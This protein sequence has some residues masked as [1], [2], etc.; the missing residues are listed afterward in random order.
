MEASKQ[1]IADLFNTVA[2]TYDTV[3]PFFAT[4]AAHLV[5]AAGLK[6]GERVLDLACGRGACLKEAVSAV[7]ERGYVLGLDISEQMVDITA[8]EL[9][10]SGIENAE[11]RG[12]DAEQ[13]DLAS[14]SFDAILCGFGVFFFPNPHAA[15]MECLR[16]LRPGGRLAVSIFAGGRGGYPW[17]YDIAR[18]LGKERQVSSSPLRTEEGLRTALD[19][20]GFKRTRTED[21]QARFIV[22]NVDALI[23]WNR[24]VA[25]RR[26]LDSLSETELSRYRRLAAEHLKSH[27][28][29]GG[30]ELIQSAHLTVAYRDLDI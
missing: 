9:C 22:E 24:S 28:V 14:A 3:I 13:L 18:E 30:F 23:A 7:G 29:P 27:A 20:A 19:R 6:Q 1:H 5:K 21:C 26:L 10:A 4:F 8:N 25:Q 15:L 2:V 16:V 11:V 12:G 17:V